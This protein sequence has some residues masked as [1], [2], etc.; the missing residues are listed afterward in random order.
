LLGPVAQ[1]QIIVGKGLKPRRLADGEGTAL[2]RIRMDEIMPVL[3]NVAGYR[4][5]RTVRELHPEAI[6]KGARLPA[7]VGRREQRRI[8][9]AP[10]VRTGCCSVDRG[11][12]IARKVCFHVAAGLVLGERPELRVFEP[13]KEWFV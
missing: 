1:K 9:F 5:R 13:L 7:L 4:R 8:I 2:R 11:K 6:R 10:R 3:R 12:Q